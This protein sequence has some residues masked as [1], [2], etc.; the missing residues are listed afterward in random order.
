MDKYD[1]QIIDQIIDE[2]VKTNLGNGS[3]IDSL[4]KQGIKKA[5]AK[6][7]AKTAAGA[8]SKS[9]ASNIP[10]SI[11]YDDQN[12]TFSATV[13]SRK[14]EHPTM[15]SQVAEQEKFRQ[16]L[17]GDSD[18]ISANIQ[19][20][21]QGPKPT[22]QYQHVEG[23]YSSSSSS[24]DNDGIE[25]D[26]DA[27]LQIMKLNMKSSMHQK[28]NPQDEQDLFNSQ[29]GG[30][31]NSKVAKSLAKQNLIRNDFTNPF[32][33]Q[34]MFEVA[35]AMATKDILFMDDLSSNDLNLDFKQLDTIENAKKYLKLDKD[36]EIVRYCNY[37]HDKYITCAKKYQDDI[38]IKYS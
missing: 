27:Q 28:V 30:I 10:G 26:L 24:D 4:K 20:R 16:Q 35:R 23:G 17:F 6:G 38:D 19:N 2:S 22:S 34:A 3:R 13:A 7:D 15:K 18:E 9:A 5:S 25:I 36:D 14:T 12:H 37:I 11:F 29:I 1:D 33:D 8:S 21:Q 31:Q 32:K